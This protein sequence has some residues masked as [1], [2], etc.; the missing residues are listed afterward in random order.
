TQLRLV[1]TRGDLLVDQ[2]IHK[3]VDAADEET[4]YARRSADVALCRFQ[5]FD[6]R[7]RDRFVVLLREQQRDINI[8]AFADE[9]FDGGDA[10]RC[11]RNLHHQVGPI[12]GLPQAVRSGERGIG[13]ARQVRRD[14]QADV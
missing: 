9:L 4:G 5:T 13:F 14:F 12:H 3:A 10:G 7:V 6:E 8:D 2:A 1:A 11:A